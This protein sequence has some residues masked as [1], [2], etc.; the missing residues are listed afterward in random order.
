M[1]FLEVF[2]VLVCF[3]FFI[4][5]NFGLFF[6]FCLTDLFI[7]Y[8]FG[9]CGFYELSVCTFICVS[10]AFCVYMYICFSYLFCFFLFFFSDCLTYSGLFACLLSKEKEKQG[11]VVGEDVRGDEGEEKLLS[12]YIVYEK[13]SCFQ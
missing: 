11:W 7:Y 10:H 2:T 12:E 6:F 4:S 9:C 13:K 3:V 1:V 8:G 5:Q